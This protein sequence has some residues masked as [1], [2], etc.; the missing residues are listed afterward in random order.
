[1]KEMKSKSLDYYIPL[2]PFIPVK[3]GFQVV[4]PS[5]AGPVTISP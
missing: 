1:M 2:I 3:K 4:L 5:L